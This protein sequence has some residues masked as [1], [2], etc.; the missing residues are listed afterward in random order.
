MK[1]T[2]AIGVAIAGAATIHSQPPSSDTAIEPRFEG[3]SIRPADPGASAGRGGGGCPESFMPSRGRLV[4]NC[5]TLGS[6]LS[7]AFRI[8]PDRVVGPDWIGRQGPKFVIKAR[9]AESIP[10]NQIP[11]MLQD[12]LAGRDHGFRR[13][14]NP[15]NTHSERGWDGFYNDKDQSPSWNRATD[16]WPPL[17]HTPGGA[18]DNLCRAR[19]FARH[20]RPH[21]GCDRYDATSRTL[22]GGFRFLAERSVRRGSGDANAWSRPGRTG[23]RKSRHAIRH[24][25][26]A[27]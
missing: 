13:P 21:H 16:R 12:L 8:P 7:H 3:A 19:G 20:S 4:M 22:P 14:A 10:E 18:V 9:F 2:V 1:V 25:Q 27:E 26:C 11:G 6:L 5:A 17:H 15:R 23:Q 24:P